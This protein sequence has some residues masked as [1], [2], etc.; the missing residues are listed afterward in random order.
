MKVYKIDLHM[1]RHEDARRSVIRF[2]EDHWSEE[3]E[4]EIITGNS[5]RMKDVVVSVLNEYNLTF[6]IGR[7]F[8][9]NN[10]GYIVT[11]TG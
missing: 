2:I 3:A 6:Q 8:D 11:W 9:T 10:R 5:T 1:M 4:L 7:M